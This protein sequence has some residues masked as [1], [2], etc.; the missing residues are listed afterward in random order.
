MWTR[1]ETE[2]E[3]NSEMAYRKISILPFRERLFVKSACDN[4]E[5]YCFLLNS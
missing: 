4:P 3:G 1:F 2:A 5:R